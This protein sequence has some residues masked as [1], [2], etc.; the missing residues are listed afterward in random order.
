MAR[1]RVVYAMCNVWD[2]LFARSESPGQSLAE[3]HEMARRAVELDHRDAE[4]D[5]VLGIVALFMRR[6]DDALRRLETALEI[7]TNLALAHMWGGGYYALSCQPDEARTHLK[8]ALRLSPRD[9]ANYWTFAFQGLADF[10]DGRY[11]HAAEWAR[12][13]IHLYHRFPTA[14][15]LLAASCTLLGQSDAARSAVRALLGSAPGT[16]IA[17]TRAAVPWKDT[18]VMERYLDALRNA[19]LPE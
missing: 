3:A 6:F 4:A 2:V 11:D 1:P 12:K 18:A 17:T 14:H 19:G 9:P 5:T 16:T 8:E 13:A 10:A 7:D 15:R